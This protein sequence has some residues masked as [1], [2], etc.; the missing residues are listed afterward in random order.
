[1]SRLTKQ[2][3]TPLL[4][5]IV[6]T[7]SHNALAIND[8][9]D[10]DYSVDREYFDIP[11]H[12]ELVIYVPRIWNF[13]FTKTDDNTPP[14]ITFYVLDNNE[15]EIFQ[16]NMSVFWDDGYERK[17]TSRE[18][19]YSLV[20]QTGEKTLEFSDQ[21]ELELKEIT[22]ASGIG[23]LY[24]LTDSNAKENEYEYLTQGALAVGDILLVF[25]LFSNDEEPLLR[26]AVLRSLKT[27]EHR[28]RRDV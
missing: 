6:F 5:L 12:G 8:N 2:C 14:L 19:I 15:E 28:F 3:I 10:P 25:S 1:M 23:Y 11:G 20:E 26:E 16:L 17:I 18:Y 27:A 21:T 7:I 4:F 24:D 22:G 13:N 9:V